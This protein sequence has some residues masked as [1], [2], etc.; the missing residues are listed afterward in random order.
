MREKKQY[1][2][3]AGDAETTKTQALS[4]QRRE[5]SALTIQ[6]GV[7]GKSF[8]SLL[9][10]LLRYMMTRGITVYQPSSTS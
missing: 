10:I 3:D 6:L 8:F 7:G 4:L 5:E 9:P 1:G 2:M